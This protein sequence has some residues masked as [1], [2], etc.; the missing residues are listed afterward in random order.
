MGEVVRAPTF[1]KV[2]P[3]S[4]AILTYTLTVGR[5]QSGVIGGDG[6]GDGGGA[7]GGGIGKPLVI[8]KL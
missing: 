5:M 4:P 6:G 2:D 1:R 7:G 8:F 3:P